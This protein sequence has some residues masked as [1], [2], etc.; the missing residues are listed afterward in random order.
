MF[1]SVDICGKESVILSFGD[2]ISLGGLEEEGP[3]FEGFDHG[4]EFIVIIAGPE[5][6]D[7]T[8]PLLCGLH[9]ETYRL[10]IGAGVI[11]VGDC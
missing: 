1:F 4:N 5:T 11:G 10:G 9:I 7:S 6:V 2:F 8:G 3:Q